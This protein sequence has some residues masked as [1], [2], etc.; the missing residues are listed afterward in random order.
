MADILFNK[1]DGD[2]MIITGKSF[3]A[4]SSTSTLDVTK[5]KSKEKSDDTRDVFTFENKE[6]VSWG[7]YNQK[8]DELN[9]V[10]KGTGVL[11]TGLSFKSRVC[12]GQGVIPVTISGYD[13]AQNEVFSVV[14]DQDIVNYINGYQFRRYITNSFK[15]LF[16]LG[17]TFPVLIL[18]SGFSKIVRVDSFNATHCRISKDKTSLL[19]FGNFATQSPQKDKALIIPMLDEDDPWG[20]LQWLK[21]KDK[22][23]AAIAFPRIKNFFC[24]NDYYGVAD[25]EAAMEAGWIDI[26]SEVPKFIK[27]TYQ[28]AM[29][30]KYHVKIPREFWKQRFPKDKYKNEGDRERAINEYMDNFDK[31]LSGFEGASK[32]IF[33][34]FTA[35]MGRDINDKWEIDKLDSALNNDEKL[36]T[37]AAANSEILFALMVN[38]SVLGA[39]MP[40]G[41]YSGNAGSGSDIRE[42]FM[43]SALLSHIERQQVLDP[44]ELMLQFNGYNNI[45]LKYKQLYLTTLDKGKATESKLE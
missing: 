42:A 29:T 3:F 40:G 9:K 6:Y 21:H 1:T 23:S 8:P 24:S 7:S 12:F 15:D 44:I 27:R 5:S 10:I 28:N 35:E 4:V 41:P 22:L 25:W 26:A 36:S 34:N 43:V 39:G 19:N 33:T 30:L 16:K 14:K 11:R 13:D 2:P 45:Q 17:N 20:H 38:P 31:N 37:S 32:T 18:N